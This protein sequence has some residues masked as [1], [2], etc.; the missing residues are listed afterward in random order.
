M[1]LD[2]KKGSMGLSRRK[3]IAGL[4][5]GIA[6]GVFVSPN[7]YAG[8]VPSGIQRFLYVT[9]ND[10]AQVDVF[11]IAAGHEFVRSFP[12]HG[13]TV[14][15]V[16]A[17]AA[18]G[19]LFVSQQAEDTVTSYD[20][21]TGEVLWTV[22]TVQAFGLDHP[23]RICINK[24][25]TAV[26]VPMKSS[27]STL[28]LNPATGQRVAQFDRP[29]RPHNSFTGE[30]DRYIYVAGRSHDTLYLADPRTHKVVKRI[31]PFRWPVR[32]F[33]VDREEHYV[34]TNIT[35]QVGFAVAA[36]ETGKINEISHLPPKERLAHWDKVKSGLPHGDHPFSHGIAG[37][38]GAKEVW[39]LDDQ[40]GYLNVFDT[41]KSPFAPTFKG[42]VELFDAIDQPWG[43]DHGNRW[44]AFSID[45]KYCYPSDGSVI[46]AE[47]GKKT[48]MRISPSEKL[49]EVEFRGNR[50]VR[51]SGQMGG[52]YGTGA[53][54]PATL[55]S[56]SV[57]REPSL[58]Q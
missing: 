34:Y 10:T 39:Y 24:D 11:D 48:T 13:K 3:F 55:G 49:I 8:R 23:D 33:S 15:G 32:P 53:S 17:D 30:Q 29:G 9:N 57:R 58:R 31:G 26:Y 52:V 35:Y 27:E 51:A 47:A 16:C 21:A 50:A 2:Q 12:M 1:R 7:V 38:P 40:W 5:A 4:S 41:S 37:R 54:D 45:G 43:K 44:V 14:G 56:L 42:Q 22:N 28:I 18:S 36:I 46:D 6:G 25:G 20:L 19:R